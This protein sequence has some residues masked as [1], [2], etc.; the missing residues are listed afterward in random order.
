MLKI[1]AIIL[2]MI[3]LTIFAILLITWDYTR[4]LNRKVVRKDDDEN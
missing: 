3:L 1:L 4:R 2:A